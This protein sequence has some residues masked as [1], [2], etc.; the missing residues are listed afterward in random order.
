M[1]DIKL[2]AKKK[3]L[4]IKKCTAKEVGPSDVS[5]TA[6][7]KT[8]KGSPGKIGGGDGTKAPDKKEDPPV[9]KVGGT[10]KLQAIQRQLGDVPKDVDLL[11][12]KRTLAES[13]KSVSVKLKRSTDYETPSVQLPAR[14]LSGKGNPKSIFTEGKKKETNRTGQRGR[15]ATIVEEDASAEG[16]DNMT[17]I[18][19]RLSLKTEE[20]KHAAG[21]VKVASKAP[22]A[23]KQN[24]IR[25]SNRIG[26]KRKQKSSHVETRAHSQAKN[27]GKQAPSPDDDFLVNWIKEKIIKAKNESLK[28][29]TRSQ[30]NIKGS[31]PLKKK[32]IIKVMVKDVSKNNTKLLGKSEQ[33]KGNSGKGSNGD[34]KDVHGGQHKGRRGGSKDSMIDKKSRKPK[35]DKDDRLSTMSGENDEREVSEV[36][37]TIVDKCSLKVGQYIIMAPDPDG[38]RVRWFVVQD[39]DKKRRRRVILGAREKPDKVDAE[40]EDIPPD[41]RTKVKLPPRAMQSTDK[42]AWSKEAHRQATGGATSQKVSDCKRQHVGVKREMGTQRVEKRK[43]VL[44]KVQKFL[45]K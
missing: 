12:I 42:T 26:E 39:A 4:H 25:G 23:T 10:S 7:R 21:E 14:T 35:R 30:G 40:W 24:A 15:L 8:V 17:E 18:N 13:K 5:I 9:K 16:D 1:T 34:S 11:A 22:S 33:S 2:G 27:K 6:P 3:D 44:R 28:K 45:T 37:K 41:E 29:A 31:A 43:K 19:G 38:E 20:S 32:E 36:W